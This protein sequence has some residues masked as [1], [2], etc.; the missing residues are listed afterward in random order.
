MEVEHLILENGK[1]SHERVR[2]REKGIKSMTKGCI[3]MRRSI[4][5]LFVNL[6]IAV[7]VT[8]VLFSDNAPA[9]PWA[10]GE[11]LE[12]TELAKILKSSSQHPTII[13]VAYPVLYRGRHIVHAKFAGPASKPEG[14]KALRELV[15]SLPKTSDIVIYC[16]CC[17]MDKCPNIRPA[18]Q[19]LKEL[20]FSHVRVVD[21]PTN[22]HTDWSAKGYPVE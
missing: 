12:P 9:D 19:A 13:C 14:I 15:G 16:G 2:D 1:Q 22:L 4:L 8:P 21:L 3:R 11:L 6:T 17:P 5:L 7:M 10:K 18:Y 20:G